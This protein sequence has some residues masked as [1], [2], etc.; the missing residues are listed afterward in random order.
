MIESVHPMRDAGNQRIHFAL[1]F[2]RIFQSDVMPP[3]STARQVALTIKDA[4]TSE[5]GNGDEARRRPSVGNALSLRDLE[6][7]S[8]SPAFLGRRG[9]KG[10]RGRFIRRGKFEWLGV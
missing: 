9:I 6:G 4:V 10:Q 5:P 8:A 1:V 2:D 7:A 3:C